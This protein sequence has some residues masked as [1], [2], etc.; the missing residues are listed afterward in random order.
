[1]QNKSLTRWNWI[2][3][4]ALLIL[5]GGP[6]YAEAP[7]PHWYV[8]VH[9]GENEVDKDN[10]EGSDTTSA[11][12]GYQFEPHIAV[13]LGFIDLGEHE[14]DL[15]ADTVVEIDGYELALVATAELT[16]SLELF[17]RVGTFAWEGTRDV[18]GIEELGLEDDDHTTA[19]GMGLEYAF[20]KNV[21]AILSATRYDDVSN[22]DITSLTLGIEVEF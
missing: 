20:A 17:G 18:Q 2:M 22:G 4:A 5:L 3:P 10:W 15:L 16:G 7:Q 8:S 21:G 11:F 19:Y 6:V 13:E 9:G 12:V 14:F 1:M